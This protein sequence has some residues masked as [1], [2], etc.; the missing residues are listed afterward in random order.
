MEEDNKLL[1]WAVKLDWLN[2]LSKLKLE[3]ITQIPKFKKEKALKRIT[4]FYGQEALLE[5]E[6]DLLDDL[7]INELKELM[8]KELLLNERKQERMEKELRD[9]V[10]PLKRGSII[11]IDPRDLKDFKGDP[12]DMLKYFYKKFLGKDD[13]ENDDENDNYKED[14]THY[15]I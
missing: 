9:K 2:I 1:S 8:K 3:S 12:E 13:D 6:P 11:K 15:Y 7:V 10:I 4:K 14:N 5:F